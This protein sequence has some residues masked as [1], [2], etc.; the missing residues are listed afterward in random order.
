MPFSEWHWRAILSDEVI[1]D[2]LDR[3]I[4]CF[5]PLGSQWKSPQDNPKITESIESLRS[6]FR[7]IVF[8]IGTKL[9]TQWFLSQTLF[10]HQV[11]SVSKSSYSVVLGTFSHKKKNFP[12]H[13]DVS[14]NSGTPKSSILIR[15]FHYK[16]SMSGGFALF[17]ETHISFQKFPPRSFVICGL[18]KHQIW[19]LC[20]LQDVLVVFGHMKL[21][22]ASIRRLLWG[23]VA[24]RKSPGSRRLEGG[25]P[26]NHLP[27][28]F[29][30]TFEKWDGYINGNIHPFWRC[31]CLLIDIFVDYLYLN[32][33]GVV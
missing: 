14:K 15:V 20:V 18:P 3:Y 21:H 12:T 7:K 33:N 26:V 1:G 5:F 10:R 25:K 17:S 11:M 8:R 13:L 4:F 31:I 9:C 23:P 32:S 24:L 16:P 22:G 29:R 30:Q 19:G 27:G 2:D 6:I 28:S